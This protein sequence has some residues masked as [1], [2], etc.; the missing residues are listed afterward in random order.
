MSIPLRACRPHLTAAQGSGKQSSFP[1]N[2]FNLVTLEL[3][4]A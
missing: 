3:S 4:S 2:Q 1:V